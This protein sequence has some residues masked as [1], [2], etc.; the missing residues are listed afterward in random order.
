MSAIVSLQE[1]D[2]RQRGETGLNRVMIWNKLFYRLLLHWKSGVI[3][4]Q[5]HS[6]ERRKKK[7]AN[8]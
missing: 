8:G 1:T 3:L 7:K 2:E 6:K 5:G 4:F